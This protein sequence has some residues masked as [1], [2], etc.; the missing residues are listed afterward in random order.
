MRR[1]ASAFGLLLICLMMGT[2]CC[3][4]QPPAREE[5]PKL[6]TFSQLVKKLATPV[7][8]DRGVDAGT[9]LKDALEFLNDRFEVP[10]L[11]DSAAFKAEGLDSVEEIAVKLP[12]MTAVR[13]STVLRLLLDQVKGTY[14][15]RS[16]YIEVTT[17][18]QARPEGWPGNESEVGRALLPLVNAEFDRRPLQEALKELSNASDISVIVDRRVGEKEAKTPVT[19]TLKNV[20]LG[21]AVRLLA[22]MAGLGSILVDNVL[23]VTAKDNAEIFQENEENRR[24]PSTNGTQ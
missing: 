3:I 17:L 24:F 20:P 7:N 11:V 18:A 22:D 19:A 2:A 9:P 1:H 21:T 5:T 12:R 13:L 8:L 15:I 16:E 4:A 23:Y 14:M 6:T 10:I